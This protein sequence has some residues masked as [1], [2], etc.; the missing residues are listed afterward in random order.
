MKTLLFAAAAIFTLGAASCSKAPM[1][2]PAGTVSQTTSAAHPET[3]SP[4]EIGPVERVE[5]LPV[6]AKSMPR[7]FRAG[8]R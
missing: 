2:E 8:M 4:S 7:E 1:P 6:K 3:A 5:K